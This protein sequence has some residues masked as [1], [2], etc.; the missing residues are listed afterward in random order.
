MGR[1]PF[2]YQTE[3]ATETVP[4]PDEMQR[5]RT[6]SAY[7]LLAEMLFDYLIRQQ[8]ESTAV[9]VPQENAPA[10]VTV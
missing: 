9:A 3:F 10:V 7:D 4:F 2:I 1:K 6:Q 5:Y 8:P